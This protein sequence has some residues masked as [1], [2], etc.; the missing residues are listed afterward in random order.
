MAM[1]DGI[2]SAAQGSA[3]QPPS[4]MRTALPSR[5]M[6]PKARDGGQHGAVEHARMPSPGPS[7]DNIDSTT[8]R[9]EMRR[10][11]K[12]G[13]Q[14]QPGTDDSEFCIRANR[15]GL[16]Q[17]RYNEDTAVEEI[18]SGNDDLQRLWPIP[19]GEKRF[20]AN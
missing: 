8:L 9:P 5:R 3:K 2:S 12:D 10:S 7:A 20:A 16:Q 18:A 4:T 19:K 6:S 14:T 1:A 13:S 11:E 17:L 15:P